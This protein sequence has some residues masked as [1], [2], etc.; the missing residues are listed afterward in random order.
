MQCRTCGYGLWNLR[1]RTCPECAAP[2]APSQFT[3]RPNSVAFCCPHC[4]KAYYGTGDGGHLEPRAFACVQ[5]GAQVHED[6]MVLR[7]AAGVTEQRTRISPIP[8]L[9]PMIRSTLSRLAQTAMWSVFSPGRLGQRLPVPERAG[10]ALGYVGLLGLAFLLPALV[11]GILFSAAPGGMGGGGLFMA[12]VFGAMPALALLSILPWALTTHGVLALGGPR[13]GG[14]RRTTSCLAYAFVG[15]APVALPGAG[16][17]LVPLGVLG[18][19]LLAVPILRHGQG[20]SWRRAIVATGVLP[21]LTLVGIAVFIVFAVTWMQARLAAVQAMQPNPSGQAQALSAA[22]LGRARAP[23]AAGQGPP[24]MGELLADGSI[25][26]KDLLGGPM[27]RTDAR[28]SIGGVPFAQMEVVAPPVDQQLAA[29]VKGILPNQPYIAH[30]V[31]DVVFTYHGINLTAP[32]DPGLWLLVVTTEPSRFTYTPP[33]QTPTPPNLAV[34]LVDGSVQEIT[35]AGFTAALDAQ[36]DLRVKHGL[37]KLP[38]PR[39]VAAN[40]F[41]FPRVVEPAT[42]ATQSPP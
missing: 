5:C 22:V 12:M 34:A 18:W 10:A 24:H 15:A 19:W 7:P 28:A 27:Y 2:F 16:F 8:W 30:R 23:G 20:I 21:V 42:P 13:K 40:G 36:N 3:F 33:G 39:G 9:D 41:V 11:A 29:A 4:D 37:A 32:P 6:E 38:D 1:S 14:L 35:D 17:Y 25:T 26:V 31:G